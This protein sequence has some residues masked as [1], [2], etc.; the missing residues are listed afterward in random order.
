[1]KSVPMPPR[2][3]LTLTEIPR[4]ALESMRLITGY[5]RLVRE[6]RG[7]DGHPVLVLPGYGAADG[8]TRILRNFLKRIGYQTHALA[9][10]R[11]VEDGTDR[12]QSVDDA[13]RF[14]EK[15]VGL[16]VQRIQAIYH[17]TG[18]PVSLVGWSMGGLYALDASR[19]LPDITRQVITLGTPFGDPRGTAMFNVM[20][21]LNRS[22]VP[23]DQQD[24]E[25]WLAKA[26]QPEVPT[27]VIY[28]DRD[29]IVGEQVSRLP[30]SRQT[31]HARVD[32]THLAFAVNPTA[33]DAV[34]KTLAAGPSAP[35]RAA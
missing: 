27:T 24:F 29:G 3:G 8:S 30:D 5:E 9:L 4:A 21:R 20:R 11:N 12:I 25:G 18:E 6:H 31:R 32:S 13:L 23:L 19:T 35:G 22:T 14:R 28:S 1:M 2:I 15:M 34:A 16:V 10:G 26:S 17:E 7:G 33:L